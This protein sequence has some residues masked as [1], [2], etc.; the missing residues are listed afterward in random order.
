MARSARTK[1]LS[2]RRCCRPL[3]ILTPSS[4]PDARPLYTFDVVTHGE[5]PKGP[6]CDASFLSVGSGVRALHAT[7]GNGVS[8]HG[9]RR[10]SQ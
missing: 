9:Q 6:N 7:T 10:L 8:G 5:P 2:V 3:P 1:E 4:G